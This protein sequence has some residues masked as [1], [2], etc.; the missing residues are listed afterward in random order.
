MFTS[1][2]VMEGVFITCESVLACL[3]KVEY[4]CG[5]HIVSDLVQFHVKGE[6]TQAQKGPA[7]E[8]GR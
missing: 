2:T 3:Q 8:L 1:F 6:I 4:R 5:N 7:N